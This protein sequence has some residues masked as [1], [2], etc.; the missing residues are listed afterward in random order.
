MGNGGWRET[1]VS[2]RRWHR[3]LASLEC[4]PMPSL[5]D[6]RFRDER[7]L[8]GGER[9]FEKESWLIE[10]AAWSVDGFAADERA[11]DLL[12]DWVFLELLVGLTLDDEGQD[13]SMPDRLQTAVIDRVSDGSHDPVP[14]IEITWWGYCDALRAYLSGEPRLCLDDEN[15]PLAST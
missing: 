15:P 7:D 12:C 3:L 11:V 8:P 4:W 10:F 6:Y 9:V 2:N 1:Y 14:V 13:C 5:E